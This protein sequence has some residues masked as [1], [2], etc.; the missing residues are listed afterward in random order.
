YFESL[1]GLLGLIPLLTGVFGVCPL[2]VWTNKQACPLK[3][4]S[5]FKKEKE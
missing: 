5:I 2:R 4:C 3:N 1:W